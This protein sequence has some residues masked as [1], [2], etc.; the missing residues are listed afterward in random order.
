MNKDEI[1]QYL[2]ADADDWSDDRSRRAAEII[3]E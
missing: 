3:T 1:I 2:L